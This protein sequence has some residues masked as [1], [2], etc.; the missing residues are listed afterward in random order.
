M[1]AEEKGQGTVREEV[2]TEVAAG[3]IFSLYLGTLIRFFRNPDMT[4]EMSAEILA[5]MTEHY[6]KGISKSSR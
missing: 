3:V 6:L 4:V 1:L 5:A 2:D